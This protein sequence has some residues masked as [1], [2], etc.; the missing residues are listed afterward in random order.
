MDLITY[1]DE[2]YNS[3]I[4]EDDSDEYFESRLNADE[5]DTA[6]KEAALITAFNSLAELELDI[7]F[8]SDKL[9]SDT[10]YTDSEKAEI[11]L[12]L[13]Q[14]QCEQAL[15]ELKYDLDSPN[16]SGLSLGGLLSVQIPQNQTP[17]PRFSERALSILRPY[18]LA[19]IV[20][21]TR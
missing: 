12:A 1:P 4:S 19:R 8:D 2:N 21:R 20:S 3:Y 16:I 6:N 13:Q 15:H 18:I 9:L 7:E 11:L 17:P 5:W 10:T 14:A